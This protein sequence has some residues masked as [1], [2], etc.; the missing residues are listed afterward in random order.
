M[1]VGGS[2]HRRV[3]PGAWLAHPVAEFAR[4][5]WS[6]LLY[7]CGHTRMGTWTKAVQVKFFFEVAFEIAFGASTRHGVVSIA[8]TRWRPQTLRDHQETRA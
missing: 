5:R 8:A 2:F 3:A 4:P 6:F 7:S 1:V